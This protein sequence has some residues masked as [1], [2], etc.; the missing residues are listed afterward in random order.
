MLLTFGNQLSQMGYTALML[1]AIGD[2]A[3]T[4]QALVGAGADLNQGDMVR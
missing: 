4:V 2:H 1:A 3:T